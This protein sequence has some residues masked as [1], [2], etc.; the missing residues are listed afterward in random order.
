[1][2]EPDWSQFPA[3]GRQATLEKA[4]RRLWELHPGPVT[5][6]ET[7]T[8]RDATEAGRQ[9]DGW[10]T[11]AWAWYA[12][13][14]SGWVWTIDVDRENINVSRDVVNEYSFWVGFSCRD[15][16]QSLSLFHEEFPNRNIHL[17]YLDSLDYAPGHEAESE[18]HHLAEAQAT[19]PALA[20]TCLVLIDDTTWDSIGIEGKGALA[21]P[22]LMDQGFTVEWAEGGQALM[23]RVQP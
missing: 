20:P 16:V 3:G 17:L 5:I 15:S 11:L 14:V 21:I 22:W 12:A 10:S 23:S 13:Q 7:G 18:R 9:G 19:L 6:V 4:L 1:M 8:T 2:T